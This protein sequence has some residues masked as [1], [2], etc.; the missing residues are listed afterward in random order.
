MII[1]S[2]N[3]L[4]VQRS[5]DALQPVADEHQHFIN[6]LPTSDRLPLGQLL[7]LSRTTDTL[8]RVLG[9]LHALL[10]HPPGVGSS[11]P[12]RRLPRPVRAVDSIAETG[13]AVPAA[14]DGGPA[15]A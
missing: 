5:I 7:S 3:R 15:A 10:D 8:E 6:C 12:P 14:G 11:Q 2:K 9:E 4:R 13:L 1:D